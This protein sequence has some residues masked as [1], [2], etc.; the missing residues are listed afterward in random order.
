[1]KP[2]FRAAMAVLVALLLSA[3]ASAEKRLA[4]VIGIDRYQDLPPLQNAVAD[5]VTISRSLESL[6]FAVTRADDP[7]RRAMT[8]R[9][10]AFVAAIEPG[11]IAFLFFSGQGVQIDNVDWL[12]PSDQPRPRE[13]EDIRSHSLALHRIVAEVMAASPRALVAVVDACRDDPFAKSLSRGLLHRGLEPVKPGTPVRPGFFLL[14]SAGSG[15]LALD[16]LSNG[17]TVPNSV[18][19]RVFA[20]LLADRSLTIQEIASRTQGEV[21]RLA[22]GV[23]MVQTPAYHDQLLGSLR[24]A[25]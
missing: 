12:I 4:L 19:T 23:G 14:W 24:L 17:D 11:D 3:Q 20:P 7:D 16:A 5:A 10:R 6:G 13:T 2:L 22:A 9:V 8:D 1:M 21:A 15:Q 25:P 18:F